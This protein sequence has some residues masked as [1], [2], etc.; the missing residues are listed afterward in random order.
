[1]T[2]VQWLCV[3]VDRAGRRLRPP[4]V[5]PGVPGMAVWAVVPTVARV[6]GVVPEAATTV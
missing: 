6:A 2:S 5:S 3:D 1:M 4:A